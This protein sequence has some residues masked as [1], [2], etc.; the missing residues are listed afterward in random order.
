MHLPS[1]TTYGNIARYSCDEC[2]NI[3]GSSV[4]YC[5]ANGLWLLPAPTCQGNLSECASHA[6][7][8]VHIQLSVTVTCLLLPLMELLRCLLALNVVA[9]LTTGALLAMS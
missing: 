7:S 1:G 6:Y 3:N 5:G 9:L 4:Q 2:S 8:D